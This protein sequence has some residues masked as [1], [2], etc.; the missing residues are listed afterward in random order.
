MHSDYTHCSA[1]PRLPSK[2]LTYSDP[3]KEK[4]IQFFLP[5]QSLEDGITP[6]GPV[7]KS[8]HQH[9]WTHK[10]TIVESYQ[11]FED[12]SLWIPI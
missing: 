7:N 5:V 10:N 12:I 1:L 6:R 11:I 3:K 4:T 8:T 9:T 2:L